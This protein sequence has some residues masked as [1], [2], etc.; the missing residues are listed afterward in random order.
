M[1][2]RIAGRQARAMVEKIDRTKLVA[3]FSAI[4]FLWGG[5]Y[6]A[7][8]I[9]LRSISVF[10]PGRIAIDSRRRHS[11]GAVAAE[12]IAGAELA[13]LARGRHQ[14]PPLVRGLPRLARLRPAF[15]TFRTI[16]D[17]PGDHSVLDR[18]R[19][20]RDRRQAADEA[21]CRA[22]ARLLRRRAHRLERDVER[23]QRRAD[24]DDG[25][26]VG[27]RARLGARQRLRAAARRAHP[28]SRS[29]RHA[30]PLRRGGIAWTSGLAGEWTSFA[31][32]E[33]TIPSLV[34]LLYL[35]L[36]G[37]VIGNTA[38]LWLLDRLPAPVVATYTFINPVVAVILGV[39]VLGE[40][41]AWRSLIGAALVIASIVALLSLAGRDQ[42]VEN[43]QA[44]HAQRIG[45]RQKAR[46][47]DQL[48]AHPL[49]GRGVFRRPS[50]LI[51]RR[52]EKVGWDAES[53]AQ[54]LHHRHAQLPLA[55]Q[56]LAH[57]ARRTQNRDQVGACQS[58][59]IHEV[60][61]QLRRARLS[62]RPFGLF[63]GG[64]QTGLSLEFARRRTDRPNSRADQPT[65]GRG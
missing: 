10:P 55:I 26:P 2:R 37:S 39:T 58:M 33:V 27:S 13:G 60:T 62:A 35:A 61:Y 20:S 36:L 40:H 46:L 19:Q 38:Y 4:Y 17:H 31:P 59:L 3:A 18:A 15:R 52:N 29:C 6:L 5:T 1:S 30:A 9:G 64:D 65:P 41:I 48:R 22:R 49:S 23:L 63:V 24:L 21:T 7:I 42:R 11:A 8:A 56:H 25:A 14:R 44:D 45:A 32:R 50:R 12:A 43:G 53:G 57:P 34:A 47:T 54:S 28:A 51:W 16:G